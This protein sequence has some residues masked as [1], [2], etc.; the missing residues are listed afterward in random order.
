MNQNTF[1][2]HEVDYVYPGGAKALQ[3]ISMAIKKGK[4]VAVL[5]PNGAGKST[6]FLHLNGIL[7]PK[8]GKVYFDGEDVKYTRSALADLRKRVGIVFQDPD[9]QLFAGNVYQD[10]S[11]GPINLGLKEAEVKNRVERALNAMRIQN[12]R[13]KPTHHLSYGQKKRVCI[14]GVLAMEPEVIIFDEPTAYLDPKHSQELMKILDD[15]HEA[16]KQVILST[17]DVNLV[18]TWSDYVFVMKNGRVKYQGTPLSIF[19]NEPLLKETHLEKPL[20]FDICEMLK[21]KGFLTEEMPRTLDE[22][23]S[24]LKELERCL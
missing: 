14:A 22:L 17:H 10:V 4:R 15:L 8:K 23:K 18:Y 12:L 3:G 1:E 24:K 2:L 16:G 13:D 5:G 6:M 20:L 7:R 19:E 9:T 21:Q 11:F